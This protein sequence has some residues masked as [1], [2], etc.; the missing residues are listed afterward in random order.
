[1]K[2]L[3]IGARGMLGQAV[4]KTWSDLDPVGTDLP[5]LDITNPPSIARQLDLYHP[6]VVVNCAAYT[7]VDKCETDEVT[8][9]HINGTAVGFLAKA[10]T[11]RNIRLIHVST[12]YVFD[13]TNEQEYTED[14]TVNPVNAYG[15][16]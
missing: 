7:N 11:L 12:D 5:E 15:R 16:S 9:N 10:C 13:G 3:I 8:A 4:M 6:D 14:A 1:M 2:S